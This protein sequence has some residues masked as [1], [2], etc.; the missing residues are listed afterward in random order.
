[1]SVTEWL[2]LARLGVYRV[3]EQVVPLPGSFAETAHP[4]PM[5][6]FL[7]PPHASCAQ[8]LYSGMKPDWLAITYCLGAPHGSQPPSD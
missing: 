6:V 8:C 4:Q 1:M 3:T 7:W 5:V 2:G